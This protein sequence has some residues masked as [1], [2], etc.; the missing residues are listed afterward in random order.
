MIEIMSF[1]TKHEE[2]Q[3]ENI[4]KGGTFYVK[5]EIQALAFPL[6]LLGQCLRVIVLL[7]LLLLRIVFFF[8]FYLFLK[9]T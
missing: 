4:N 9:I 7:F 6:L 8:F 1:T 5:R 3:K 2:Q